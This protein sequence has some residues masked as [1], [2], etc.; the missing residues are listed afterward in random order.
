MKKKKNTFEK[1]Y[2]GDGVQIEKAKWIALG[3]IL[4]FALAYFI[5]ELITGNISFKKEKKAET[6]IQYV[7]ILAEQ[8]FKQP[9]EEYF[10][11]FYSFDSADASLL[12]TYTSGLSATAP[13][14][15]VDLN[16]KFNTD[17]ITEGDAKSPTSIKDLKVKDPTLIRVKN[18]K[19]I[20]FVNG[21]NNIK[22][23]VSKL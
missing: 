11:L 17:F 15:K 18:K 12:N 2:N 13:V 1:Q 6:S 8:T 20:S 9:E 10:I 3:I 22:T 7:E 23:Y 21:L 16:K 4:F 19:S 5:G 14:Y